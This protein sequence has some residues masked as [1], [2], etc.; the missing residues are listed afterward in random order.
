MYIVLIILLY[1]QSLPQDEIDY[2]VIHGT[3]LVFNRDYSAAMKLFNEVEMRSPEHP[4]PTL[5]RMLVFQAMLL[6]RG[7]VKPLPEFEKEASKNRDIIKNFTKKKN[8]SAWEHIYISASYAINGLYYV[9]KGDYVQGFF[10]GLKGMDELK[11]A[12]K[13]G[14]PSDIYLG[15]G[16]FHYLAGLFSD[17]IPFL[18]KMNDLKETGLKEIKISIDKGRYTK[19]YGMLALGMAYLYEERLQE[20]SLILEELDTLFPVNIYVKLILGRVYSEM[21]NYEKAEW[22]IKKAMEIDPLNPFSN[23]HLGLTYIEAGKLIDARYNVLLYVSD[24]DNER[25]KGFA[26]Y[27]LGKAEYENHI[28]DEASEHLSQ[29]L[30]FFKTDDAERLLREIKA[31]QK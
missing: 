21:K 19:P 11:K 30:R 22:I 1:T 6:E 26:L 7:S 3:E 27:L 5:G 14:N 8:L 10:L 25:Y 9:R 12:S 29:S 17:K 16:L 18:G 4:V 28:I 2:A 15:Y 13:K 20:A 31:M 23:L 24:G